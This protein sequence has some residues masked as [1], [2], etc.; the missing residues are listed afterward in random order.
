MENPYTKMKMYG[1]RNNLRVVKKKLVITDSLIPG[2]DIKT[3]VGLEVPQPEFDFGLRPPNTTYYTTFS[4]DPEPPIIVDSVQ[5][6]SFA[7]ILASFVSSIQLLTG[8]VGVLLIMVN[9]LYLK[10]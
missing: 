1:R 5:R 8:I 3:I 7:E 4:Y 6:L 2:A 9:T 10:V